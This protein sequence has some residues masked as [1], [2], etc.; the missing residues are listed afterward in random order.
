MNTDTPAAPAQARTGRAGLRVAVDVGGTSIAVALVDPSTHRIVSRDAVPTPT[1]SGELVT[2]LSEVVANL[3]ADRAP[4][5]VGIGI[6]G[7]VDP[8]AGTVARAV[9]LGIGAEP[10]AL[11]SEL[12]ERLRLDVTIENDTRAAAFGAARVLAP[13]LTDVAVL[14]MGTGVAAGFVID[15]RIHRG[16]DGTAGEIGHANIGRGGRRCLCGGDGCLETIVSGPALRQRWPQGGDRA[17][18]ALFVAAAGPQADPRASRLADE[19]A[20][21]IARTVQLIVLMSGVDKVFLWGAVGS[22]GSPL[23]DRVRARLDS[24]GARSALTRQ[25]C[26]GDRLG[27]VPD[28]M[29]LGLLGAAMLLDRPR[30]EAPASPVPSVQVG[31]SEQR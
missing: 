15:G 29:P 30:P 14:T 31:A 25:L 3:V 23:A 5:G 12:A 20:E 26:P 13:E 11:A 18:E 2:C 8:V 4:I 10:V 1:G 28:G 22:V 19:V 6:P 24:W 27:D 9:N 16:P 17:A 21:E 7:I